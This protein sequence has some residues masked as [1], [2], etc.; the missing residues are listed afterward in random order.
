MK[1]YADQ[2]KGKQVRQVVFFTLIELLVVIAIIA[3]LAALLLPS[4]NRA[5]DQA[6]KINCASNLKQ[7]GTAVSSYVGDFDYWPWPT[8]DEVSGK[9]WYDIMADNKYLKGGYRGSANV[10]YLRCKGHEKCTSSSSSTAPVNSYVMVGT[11]SGSGSSSVPWSGMFGV[12]G[13]NYSDPTKNVFPMRPG[14]FRNPSGKIGVAE[15]SLVNEFGMGDIA[16]MRSLFNGTSTPGLAP[17][18]GKTF[19]SQFVDG[20]VENL[21]IN[22]FDCHGDVATNGLGSKIWQKYFAVNYP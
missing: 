11:A 3:I 10:F 13:R 19:N 18:H 15:R 1:G 20:H 5:R 14:K 9:R 6:Y 2:G 12:S 16:D 4:L 7:I 17:L 21:S 8:F 22:E